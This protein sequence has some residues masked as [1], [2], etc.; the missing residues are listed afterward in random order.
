MKERLQLDLQDLKAKLQVVDSDSRLRLEQEVSGLGRQMVDHQTDSHSAAESLSLRIQALEAQN[1][2]V[3]ALN[4][5]VK[6]ISIFQAELFSFRLCCYNV[7]ACFLQLSQ[8]WSSIQLMPPPAPCP[9]TSTI[10]AQNQLTPELQQAMEKWFTDRI[11]V[12]GGT[13]TVDHIQDHFPNLKS[14]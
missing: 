3:T 10:L 4:I 1:A 12:R 11:K 2:K 7:T 8:E 9:E 5:I 14:I 13:D 6:K